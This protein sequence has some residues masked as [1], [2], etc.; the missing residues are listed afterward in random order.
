M[1]KK[2]RAYE[3]RANR[4]QT[5]DGDGQ[6]YKSTMGHHRARPNIQLKTRVLT[7]Q[8]RTQEALKLDSRSGSGVSG[9]KSRVSH[10][11]AW[12]KRQLRKQRVLS[13]RVKTQ[14][15]LSPEPR[16]RRGVQGH[17][18]RVDHHNTRLRRLLRR[19]HHTRA[20]L[21]KLLR[22]KQRVLSRRSNNTQSASSPESRG[23]RSRVGHRKAWLNLSYPFQ[24]PRRLWTVKCCLESGDQYKLFIVPSV[25]SSAVSWMLNDLES[26]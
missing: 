3:R 13:G 6:G 21:K 14:A 2:L 24:S 25:V 16:G 19:K 26:K 10:R 17:R 9:Q 15:A 4:T 5:D 12:P 8:N 11:R 20:W 1:R 18:S 7:E 22:R 23:S